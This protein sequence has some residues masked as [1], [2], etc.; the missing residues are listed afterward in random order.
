MKNIL[1]AAVCFLAPIVCVVAMNPEA[2]QECLKDAQAW[3]QKTFP[4][5]VQEPPPQRV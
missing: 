3:A 4:V 5:P 1:I 2:A